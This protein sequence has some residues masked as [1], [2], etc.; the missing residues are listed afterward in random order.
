MRYSLLVISQEPG[1]AEVSE[2]A[3]NWGGGTRF[4][5][6]RVRLR[7][8]LVAEHRFGNGVVHL[9]YR[10]LPPGDAL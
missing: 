9:Q 4:Y 10:A 1:D 3:M 8:Q 2:E 5:P 6:A 7:V